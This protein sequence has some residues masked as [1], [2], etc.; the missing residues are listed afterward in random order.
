MQQ[1][2]L[3]VVGIGATRMRVIIGKCVRGPALG[4]HDQDLLKQ[5][6]IPKV[7]IGRSSLPNWGLQQAL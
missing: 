4:C 6:L 1:I 5:I 7:Q 3:L 2:W